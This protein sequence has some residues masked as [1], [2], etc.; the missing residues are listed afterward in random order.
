MDE[1]L[2]EGSQ[3]VQWEGTTASAPEQCHARLLMAL[4][5]CIL[6]VCEYGHIMDTRFV[7]PLG[8]GPVLDHLCNDFHP[9]TPRC[10]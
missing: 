4:L 7:A 6:T 1:V 3:C 5:V 8:P 2:T 9:S 10:P